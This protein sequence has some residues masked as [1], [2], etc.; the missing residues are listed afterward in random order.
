[1]V[2]H[3]SRVGDRLA[4]DFDRAN[5]LC[6][7]EDVSVLD[8]NDTARMHI[9]RFELCGDELSGREVAARSPQSSSRL[10][11]RSAARLIRLERGLASRFV[12][13]ANQWGCFDGD[14]CHR[15]I[16]SRQV[17]LPSARDKRCGRRRRASGVS[18]G[19]TPGLLSQARV[20]PGRHRGLRQR[21]FLGSRDPGLR[22]R[23]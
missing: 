13:H 16:G 9:R 14:Y 4:A 3:R 8:V 15:R 1:M 10:M 5:G 20:V 23:G 19:P 7:A 2:N 21:A 22:A 12:I 6:F 11:T 18:S 17:G